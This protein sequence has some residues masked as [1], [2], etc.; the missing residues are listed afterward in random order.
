MDDTAKEQQ[1]DGQAES[2]KFPLRWVEALE[3]IKHFNDE[4]P[5]DQRTL[6]DQVELFK[7]LL[8]R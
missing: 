3:F 8:G 7:V 1:Q 2:G 5:S 6:A 4:V